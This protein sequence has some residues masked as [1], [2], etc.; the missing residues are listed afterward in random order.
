[1][2]MGSRVQ[3][4]NDETRARMDVCIKLRLDY[5]GDGMKIRTFGDWV[6]EQLSPASRSP[7]KYIKR[8][9]KVSD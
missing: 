4:L 2:R 3:N 6:N 9:I 1:M 5:H 7:E 8:C